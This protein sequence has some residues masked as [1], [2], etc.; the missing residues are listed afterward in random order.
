MPH[1]YILLRITLDIEVH[2]VVYPSTLFCPCSIVRGCSGIDRTSH[3]ANYCQQSNL[4][5]WLRSRLCLSKRSI[6]WS[7]HQG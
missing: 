6:P 3:G 7:Y 1:L 5:R 2:H 4:S